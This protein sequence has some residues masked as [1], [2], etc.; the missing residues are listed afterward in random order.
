[1]NDNSER[2]L[3]VQPANLDL[4]FINKRLEMAGYTPEQA[5]AS[6]EAYRQFL[7]V[8]AAKPN[9]ILVPTKAADAAWHEHI[10]F[11]DRYEAD[12]KRLVGARVHHHPD[13]P[14]AASWQKAVA[15]TQDAFRATLG[16]ELPTEELAGCFLT[17]EAA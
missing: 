17:V 7:V 15:N 13:A 12:M 8:V 3:S 6:V 9:L 2:V 14:D 1:M 4:S 16:V 11:M 10:L 5:T